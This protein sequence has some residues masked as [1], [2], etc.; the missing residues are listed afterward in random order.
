MGDRASLFEPQSYNSFFSENGPSG[1][2]DPS[3]I[4]FATPRRHAFLFMKERPLNKQER[5]NVQ[6]AIDILKKSSNPDTQA[7]G[8]HLQAMLDA[9]RIN[10]N[11]NFGRLGEGDSE[12]RETQARTSGGAGKSL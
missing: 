10:V 1:M 12:D 5:S 3:S 11:T 6:R 9:G 2:G 4:F 7:A 8:N